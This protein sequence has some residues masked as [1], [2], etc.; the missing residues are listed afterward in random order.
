MK[1]DINGDV[2][3]L[4]LTSFGGWGSISATQVSFGNNGCI[5]GRMRYQK[6]GWEGEIVMCTSHDYIKGLHMDL[7]HWIWSVI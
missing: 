4:R 3:T 7:P 6:W 2:G 1:L 5:L